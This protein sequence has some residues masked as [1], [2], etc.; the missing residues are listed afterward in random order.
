[1]LHGCKNGSLTNS[2]MQDVNQFPT[3]VEYFND[4]LVKIQKLLQVRCSVIPSDLKC[5]NDR[6]HQV[7]IVL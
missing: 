7:S 5:F 4:I 6:C 2:P 1:M 3:D